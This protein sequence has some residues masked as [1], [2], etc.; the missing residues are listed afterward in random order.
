MLMFGF[1]MSVLA[2]MLFVEWQ[3]SVM[4]R[5]I[6]VSSENRPRSRSLTQERRY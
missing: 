4:R 5:R 1:F 3:Y 6:R 2:V